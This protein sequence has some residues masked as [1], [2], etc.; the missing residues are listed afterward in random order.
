MKL[1]TLKLQKK[2]EELE[3]ELK[4]N[5]EKNTLLNDDNNNFKNNLEKKRKKIEELRNEIE[6]NNNINQNKLNE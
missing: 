5:N 6:D 2:I 4:I 3:Y 1:E